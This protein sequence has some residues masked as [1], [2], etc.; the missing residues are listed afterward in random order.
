MKKGYAEVKEWFINKQSEKATRYNC[1]IDIYSR[2]E[3]G[4]VESVDGY[5]KVLFQEVISETEKAVYVVLGTG[6]ADGSYKG[7]KTW[8]PKSVIK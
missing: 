3:N 6:N 7:W 2:D 1:F 8:I 5:L 4:K